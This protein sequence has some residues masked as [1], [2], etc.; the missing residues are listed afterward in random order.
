M[1]QNVTIQPSSTSATLEWT[2]SA[3]EGS[4]PH[5]PQQP[6]TALKIDLELY[7][8]SDRKTKV[9]SRENVKSPV[10]IEHLAS[11]T[12]YTLFIT[13]IDGETEPFRLTEQFQT[14]DGLPDPPQLED[15][16]LVNS[17]SG[18][19]GQMCEIE[20]RPPKRS[21]G[22]VTRYHVQI[23]GRMRYVSPG[24][25]GEQQAFDFPTGVG[26]CSNYRDD[27]DAEGMTGSGPGGARDGRDASGGEDE[28]GGSGF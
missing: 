28:G 12:P 4:D 20:W 23:V 17:D 19:G 27:A 15:I 2:S 24:M 26:H 11:A 13:V 6:S 25:A 16:R 8:R 9:W 10:R 1:I 18:A 21:R 3:Q 14:L 5:F 22:H 7:R